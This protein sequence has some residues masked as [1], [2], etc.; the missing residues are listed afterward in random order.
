MKKRSDG[1]GASQLRPVTITRR[2]LKHPEGSCLIEMGQTK[3]ICTAS[4]QE[5]VPHHKKN[6]GMGWITAEYA[7]LPRA[8]T[9][10]SQREHYQGKT[11]GRTQ[12][13][14][15]LIGRSLRAVVDMRKLGERTIYIDTDVIQADGGT[16]TA[17]ITG[18]YVALYDAIAGLRKNRKIT[19]DPIKSALAAISVGIVDGEALLDLPYEEDFKAEVD[20]NVVMTEDG[21]I[22]EVQGTA[23]AEPFSKKQLD[24]L[25]GL[26]EKGIKALIKKQKEVLTK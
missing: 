10:R 11:R 24:E 17:A 6:S 15:R 8:T 16:R 18:A 25:L 3:V 2:Y 9:E 1:R 26:A 7:M 22:I 14:Q 19:E 12:E 23:E 4:V 20:M 5:S 21:K 13:I